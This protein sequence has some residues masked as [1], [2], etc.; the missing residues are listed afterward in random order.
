M[1]LVKSTVN[2]LVDRYGEKG[3]L[4]VAIKTR[5]AAKSVAHREFY[6]EVVAY[7]KAALALL[8]E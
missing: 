5:D 3:S 1:F 6:A 7:I 2:A 4:I 8:P